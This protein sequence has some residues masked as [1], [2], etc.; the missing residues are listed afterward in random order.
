MTGS[1]QK[2]LAKMLMAFF[3]LVTIQVVTALSFKLAQD[4]HGK[5]PFSPAA[6]MVAAEFTKFIL[7]FCF[8]AMEEAAG[9]ASRHQRDVEQHVQADLNN[10]SD[11]APAL[12]YNSKSVGS[13]STTLR[14]TADVLVN[15]I[16]AS[17]GLYKTIGLL[18]LAYC[19]NNN[20]SFA[21]F[22][23]ADG[24]TVNLV[25]GGSAFVSAILLRFALN[26]VIS[27]VQWSS[28]TLQV[29]GLVIAQY[30]VHC[31]N[32]AVFGTH[33]YGIL[34][35]S[36]VITS[37]CGV[38]N[39]K[40][41]KDSDGSASMHTVN[42]LLYMFGF[43]LN[44][45]VYLATTRTSNDV[46]FFSGFDRITTYIIL[47]CQ[48]FVGI[49]VT[50]VYKYM[51]AAAK[52]LATACATTVLL[53]I[54]IAFANA[55]FSVVVSAGCIVV[56]AATHLYVT[57]P[58]APATQHSPPQPTACEQATSLCNNRKITLF[59]LLAVSCG[60]GIGVF[61][62]RGGSSG[63]L[64][65]DDLAS[66]DYTRS[67]TEILRLAAAS[68][69]SAQQSIASASFLSLPANR[70]WIPGESRRCLLM[71]AG[72]SFVTGGSGGHAR[73]KSSSYWEQKQAALSHVDFLNTLQRRHN[74]VC[75]VIVRSYTTP[76]QARLCEWYSQGP[77][78]LIA[79]EFDRQP[80]AVDKLVSRLAQRTVLNTTYTVDYSFALF[81][82]ADLLI[83]PY[84]HR[85]FDPAWDRVRFSAMASQNSEYLDSGM[86]RVADMMMFVPKGLYWAFKA[87]V[88]PSSWEYMTQVG[89]PQ[90]RMG[91]MLATLHAADSSKDWV[92]IYHIA[93]RPESCIWMSPGMVWDEIG[94]TSQPA[95]QPG[96]RAEARSAK[97]FMRSDGG[98]NGTWATKMG[99]DLNGDDTCPD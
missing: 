96:S 9:H 1:N 74:H 3:G 4:S 64:P 51:D 22:R 84:L 97:E 50:A 25:K 62:M 35:L 78:E 27:Q 49:A 2:P 56:F 73:G 39:D 43:A 7:S 33:V 87:P 16:K 60:L 95:F 28:V 38:W 90:S 18:S 21:I 13:I 57:N 58:P 98:P 11:S 59:S 63:T 6:L 5:Y 80:T 91:F 45:M 55:P 52:A 23:L 92:P 54:D 34:F 48:S 44:S 53:V 14:H 41:L 93:N 31:D 89:V 36:L 24:F 79:C 86:P 68:K 67:K 30:G 66:G 8:L 12:A 71:V 15:Q 40:I 37:A 10:E 70:S 82:R 20:M 75:D 94:Y 81:L 19:A 72:E 99:F 47:A 29:T 61:A 42:A 69:A 17:R 88:G 83:K 32:K 26:R 85:I 65:E 46:H 77:G 76:F